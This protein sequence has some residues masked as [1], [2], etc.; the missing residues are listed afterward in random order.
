[1]TKL[2][3][4]VNTMRVIPLPYL[5]IFTALL[6]MQCQQREISVQI[7]SDTANLQFSQTVTP[8]VD[9]LGEP[10]TQLQ[11]IVDLL[12]QRNFKQA[13]QLWDEPPESSLPLF[14]ARFDNI[15]VITAT[16]QMPIYGVAAG[17]VVARVPSELLIQ[18]TNGTVDYQ[19]GCV[20]MD[21]ANPRN[22]GVPKH[23]P[24]RWHIYSSLISL[25]LLSSGDGTSR[26]I[27][28]GSPCPPRPTPSH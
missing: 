3:C 27:A 25:A 20:Y 10:R 14:Q 17:S 12:N 9:N 24:D 19:S 18:H 4:I 28:I 15:A 6:L 11:Q 5:F 16:L 7:R 2:L 23:I 26:S 22:E 1:M 21:R 13:Y 8:T